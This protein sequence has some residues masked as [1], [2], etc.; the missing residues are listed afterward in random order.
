MDRKR[1]VAGSL[2]LLALAAVPAAARADDDPLLTLLGGCR[3]PGTVI[4]YGFPGA[5][6]VWEYRTSF[7]GGFVPANAT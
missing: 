2:A 6:F 4:T 3:W 5:G 7:T 1:F